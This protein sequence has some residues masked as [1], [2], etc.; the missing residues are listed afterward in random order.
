MSSS[1]NGTYKAC[2]PALVLKFV[3]DLLRDNLCIPSK[4]VLICYG[5]TDLRLYTST[6]QKIVNIGFIHLCT[7]NKIY[8]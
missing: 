4:I 2:I 1:Q 3:G 6:K 7:K 8:I 5:S